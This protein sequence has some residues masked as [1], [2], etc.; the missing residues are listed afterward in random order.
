GSAT[1]APCASDRAVRRQ[2]DWILLTSGT[3]GRPKLVAH[4]LSSLAAPI[5]G[6]AGISTAAVWATFY[7][8]RRYG[9]LQIFLRALLGG[10]SMV[11]SAT[12]EAAT[13]FLTRAK[14]HAVTH[15]TG[16]PTHWRRAL[17]SPAARSVSPIYARLSGE[18]ADQAV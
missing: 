13:M 17:M 4:T 10:G 9:G 15:L 11:L 3:T 12:G 1:I 16:T 8:I 7:D 14:D 18:I 6:G 2:T 5:T